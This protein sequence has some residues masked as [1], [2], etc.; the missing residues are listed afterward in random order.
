MERYQHHPHH[1]LTRVA[2]GSPE[3]LL[4]GA[5]LQWRFWRVC[6]LRLAYEENRE[7]EQERHSYLCMESL[8][9]GQ[10]RGVDL[11][12]VDSGDIHDGTGLSDGGPPGSIDAY[13]VSI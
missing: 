6:E 11:L 10:E 1:R 5:E 8:M 4:S 9:S 7:S 13:E 3:N 12:L 2:F